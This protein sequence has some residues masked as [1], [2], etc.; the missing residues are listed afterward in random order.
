[1]SKE[2]IS[3][4]QAPAAIGPYSQGIKAGDFLFASGQIPLDPETGALVGEG[5]EVQTV[6]VLENVGAVLAA[7]GLG[8]EDVIKTTVFLRDMA[9][10]AAVNAV[11]STYFSAPYP[12]RSCVAVAGLP[13]DARVEIEVVAVGK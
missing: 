5:V 9:D 8:F 3:T 1:M 11:Y 7:A 10:F 13:R 12:A 6:R 4:S 2:Q